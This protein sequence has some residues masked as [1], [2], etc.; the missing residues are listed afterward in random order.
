MNT[1]L[2]QKSNRHIQHEDNFLFT[3]ASSCC[4]SLMWY[5]YL[6][7]VTVLLLLIEAAITQVYPS[8]YL[9][10]FSFDSKK[11]EQAN[12]V[13]AAIQIYRSVVGTI[14]GIVVLVTVCRFL[15]NRI[16]LFML[17]GLFFACIRYVNM[18][19]DAK[20]PWYQM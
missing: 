14:V 1:G 15:L 4:S 19:T 10:T 18:C 9:D 12:A 3:Q 5:I 17:A 6:I 8:I 2:E 20:K 16:H 7:G 11:R 13:L